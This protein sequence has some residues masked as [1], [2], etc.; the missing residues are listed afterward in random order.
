MK[1]LIFLTSIAFQILAAQEIRTTDQLVKAMHDRYIN[2]WYSTLTFVQKTTQYLPDSTTKIA[3]WYEAFSFPGT[4]RIDID[5]MGYGG[6]VLSKDSLY[7]YREGKLT[8]TR[9][10]VHSLLL[11]GFD[12]YFLPVQGTLMKL[13]SLHF[14][15]TVLREDVWQGR[16]VFVVG[17]K[18]GDLHSAQFWIDK[19]HLY[20]V[21]LLEPAGRDGS[22]T[23]ETQFNKYERL[24]QGWLSVEVI[25][26]V[27][28]KIVTTEEYSEPQANPRLDPKLF[29][30][31][32][33][34]SARWN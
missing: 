32:Y 11:L 29:D 4:M 5:S 25:F 26:K 24:D 6:M 14:D 3:T 10:F 31:Q 34:R 15:L 16:P 9:P 13:Q 33:W 12:V 30:P 7:A 20:F 17:A 22:Q 18:Q 23:R 21:R 8:A 19:E 1:K 2:K 27:D 28:G